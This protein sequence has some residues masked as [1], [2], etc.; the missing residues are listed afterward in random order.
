MG[1]PAITTAGGVLTAFATGIVVLWWCDGSGATVV[2]LV[3][4]APLSLSPPLGCWWWG[5]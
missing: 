5:L 4:L 1:P 2:V 3:Q